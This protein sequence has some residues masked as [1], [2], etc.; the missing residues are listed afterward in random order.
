MASPGNQHCAN[1]IGT[2][3]VPNCLA[4]AERRDIWHEAS[5]WLE[6]WKRRR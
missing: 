3:F 6:H 2:T 4:D 1:C 5:L